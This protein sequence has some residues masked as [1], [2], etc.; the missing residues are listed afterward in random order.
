MC[1]ILQAIYSKYTADDCIISLG[2]KDSGD[3]MTGAVQWN[4]KKEKEICGNKVRG[5]KGIKERK[6]RQYCDVGQNTPKPDYALLLGY[7]KQLDRI[8]FD[9]SSSIFRFVL[10]L[11]CCIFFLR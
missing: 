3:F 1:K 5:E 11:V 10:C 9:Q 8:I 4:R 2:R 6:L 7:F